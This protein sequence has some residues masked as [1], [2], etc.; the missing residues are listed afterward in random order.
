L[1]QLCHDYDNDEIISRFCWGAYF[2]LAE[3]VK[4]NQAFNQ[5]EEEQLQPEEK[6]SQH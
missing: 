6:V 4:M 5:K 3:E 2:G 1:D